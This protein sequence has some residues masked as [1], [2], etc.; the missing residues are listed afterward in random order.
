MAKLVGLC[1][2]KS[3]K[4]MSQK[5][6]PKGNNVQKQHDAGIFDISFPFKMGF[7]CD[8]SNL[9]EYLASFC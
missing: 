6:Y 1:Y 4:E 5:S 9:L 3:R 7:I 8:L 2:E